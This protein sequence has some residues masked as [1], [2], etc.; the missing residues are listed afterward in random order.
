MAGGTL[1][2][3]LLGIPWWVA[4]FAAILAMSGD[5][6]S[7]FCKRRFGLPSGTNVLFFDQFLES[8]LPTLYLGPLV[9]LSSIQFFFVLSLFIPIA[10]FGACLW[11]AV[12]YRPSPDNYPRVVRST[13]R[14]RE[15]RSCHTPRTR[16]QTIF[17]LSS[18]LAHQ[19]LYTWFF[20]LT[21]LH[22]KGLENTL[23]VQVEEIAFCFPSLPVS[24]DQ[25]KILLLTDLH[26]DGLDALTDTII[27]HIDT[28][29]V[30]LCLV[31]G[32]I[33]MK[34][35]GP[36]A[37]SLK[38]LSRLLPHVHARHG[39]FGVLGNHDCIEMLPDFEE[40]GIIMLVNDSW[41]IKEKNATIRVVGIDDPHYYKTHN[42]P[43]AF[44]DVADNDFSILLAHSPEAYR[45]SVPY[46]PDLYLCGHT[47]C[48]QICL[49]PFK[50]LVTNSRA[51]RFTAAGK[52]SYQGMLG[53][54]SRGVGASGVPLRFNC[55]GEIA[56]ITLCRS[57]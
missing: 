47:H 46:R 55:P 30:D 32:D 7:S 37:K 25:F 51:P 21:G 15:W 29:H 52:W 34:T 39:I 38:Q 8:L 27:E 28:I 6:L 23:K 1:V 43:L 13:V 11:G 12:M 16:W 26:L 19:V 22:N 14:W 45:E 31:G 17:N 9:G 20:R 49:S 40:A 2:F 48:G 24:F 36:M 44:Q 35:Y 3:P 54:T 5:L 10:Y 41:E 50:P 4:F 33:R 42:L 53:Y 57:E 18:L 56:I